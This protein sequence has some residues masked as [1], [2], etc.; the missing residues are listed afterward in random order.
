MREINQENLPEMSEIWQE[1]LQWQP[2]HRQQQ[3]FVQIYQE[4]LQGN[5]KLNLTRITSPEEFWEKH[6]WDSLASLL[7]FPL[8]TQLKLNVIDIGTGGGFPGLPMAVVFPHWQVTLLDSTRKKIAFLSNLA[9]KIGLTNVKT[10]VARAEVIGQ[11]AQHRETYDLA[12]IRAVGTASVCAEYA[13]PLVKLG[14]LAIL[15][16]GH[17]QAQDTEALEL[18]ATELGSKIEA[19]AALTTPISHSIRHCIYLRKHSPTPK[20][21][22][23]AVGVPNQQ[24]L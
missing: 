22:P 9:T 12:T 10:L 24:P 2:N 21:Y 3:Y 4:I 15:Y 19:I 13:L 8:D 5:R 18:V 20:Q 23:R 16:R 14:G 1:T 6:L 11:Q 17:W 7:D